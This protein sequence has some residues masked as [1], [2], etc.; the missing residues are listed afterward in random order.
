MFTLIPTNQFKKDLKTLKK[1]AI[2]NEGLIID[3]LT[4][5]ANDGA[6]GIDKKHRPH[7]LSGNYK[8]NWEA[9]IKPDMLIIWFEITA[10]DEIIL[11]RAGSHADLF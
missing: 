8:D 10:K 2:K 5:L 9:H 4:I 1:R 6:K 11:I 7:K 3:F